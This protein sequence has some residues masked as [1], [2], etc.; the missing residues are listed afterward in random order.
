MAQDETEPREVP[1]GTE[2]DD[3][4]AGRQVALI[5]VMNAT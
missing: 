4:D 1:D 2:F 3:G 5:P